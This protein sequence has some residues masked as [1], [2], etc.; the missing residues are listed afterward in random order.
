MRIASGQGAL[1]ESADLLVPAFEAGVD[2]VVCDSLAEATTSMLALDRRRDERLGYAPDLEHRLAIALPYVADRGTRLITNA[3]GVNPV[4][5]HQM[6]VAAARRD[7]LRG[8]RIGL[9]CAPVERPSGVLGREVYLG[10]AGIVRALEQGA[11]VVITGRVADAALFL[12]PALFQHDWS[13]ADWDRLAAGTVVGHLLECSNQVSGG[14]YSGDWWNTVDLL[15]VGMPL[16]EVAADGTAVITKPEGTSGRVSFDTVREQL[17]YEV[18][19]PTAYITPDVIV[20]MTTVELDEVGPD[21]VRMSGATGRPRPQTLKGLLFEP[22]GW[23]GEIAITYAWPDA[24][25]KGRRVL[26]SLRAVAEQ[27]KIPVL[28]WCEEYF[29]VNGFGGPTVDTLGDDPPEVT[30]RL[31]WRTADAEAAQDVAR[32][33]G[34]VALSGPPGLQSIGRTRRGHPLS[35][36]V[37][38]TTFFVDRDDVEPRVHV[39]VEEV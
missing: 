25:A 28:E 29:G 24:H 8:L 35:E 4:A 22:A 5:A 3:G 18:H 34:L 38:L 17:L 6:A 2:Y 13:W 21:R 20:D 27:R 33:V 23:A 37:E 26:Q 36:L 12:A 15:R 7:G 9:V 39:H 16:A 32:L 11:D 30:A 1:G 19:D 31:A 10:A 14:N